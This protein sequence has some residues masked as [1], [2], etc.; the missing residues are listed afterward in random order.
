MAVLTHALELR[1]AH[2]TPPSSTNASLE[3]EVTHQYFTEAA[4]SC[5]PT[6]VVQGVHWRAPVLGYQRAGLS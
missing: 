4:D 3:L 6:S 2:A 1:K 5:G